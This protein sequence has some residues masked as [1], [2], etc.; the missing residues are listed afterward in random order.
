MDTSFLT[1]STEGAE[2]L[3]RETSSSELEAAETQRDERK[4]HK[5]VMILGSKP[6][7]TNQNESTRGLRKRL[8]LHI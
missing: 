3:K 4:C 6:R 8:T 7:Q 2:R 5:S 1:S